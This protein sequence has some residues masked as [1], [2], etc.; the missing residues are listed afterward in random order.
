MEEIEIYVVITDGD[1]DYYLLKIE[2]RVNDVYCF[3]PDLGVHYSRHNSGESHFRHESKS[4]GTREQPPVILVMGEAGDIIEGG[5]GCSQLE[6]IGVASGICT[7]IY[8]ITSLDQDLRV[9]TRSVKECFSIDIRLFPKDINVIQV[10]IWAVP[11]RNKIS[12]EF[13][14]PDVKDN[15]L[16]KVEYC[17][18]QIWIYASSY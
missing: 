3:L 7:A 11:S 17:E 18:P 15:L 2:R 16:Y 5:I 8:S 4:K 6:E 12:F 13:N 9:F 1:K 14:N 10:G